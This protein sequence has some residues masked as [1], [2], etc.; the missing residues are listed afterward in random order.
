MRTIETVLS[1]WKMELAT[2]YIPFFMLYQQKETDRM[3][4]AGYLHLSLIIFF[5]TVLICCDPADDHSC[6]LNDDAD[7]KNHL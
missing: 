3:E 4:T 2:L 1:T 6:R 7:Q 5:E